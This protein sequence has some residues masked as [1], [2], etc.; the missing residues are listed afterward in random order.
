LVP[1][2]KVAGDSRQLSASSPSQDGNA[3][4]RPAVAEPAPAFARAAAPRANWLL[5]S[6]LLS[7]VAGYVDAAGFVSLVGLFPA[8]L[9]GELVGDVIA[10]SSGHAGHGHGH[11]W[12][13]PVFVSSVVLAT[14]VAAKTSQHGSAKS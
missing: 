8:H 4:E 6:A 1:L 3:P 7:G 10:I 5:H 11:L 12:A 9:T 2:R 14:V 13:V